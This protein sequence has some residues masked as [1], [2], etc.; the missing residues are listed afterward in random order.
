MF[1]LPIPDQLPVHQDSVLVE[2]PLPGG[3][4]ALVR[5]LFGIPQWLQIGGAVLGA[6]VAAAIAVLAWRR[7]QAMAGWLASRSREVRIGLAV[8]AVVLVLAAAGAGTVS[9]NYMQHDNGFC[10]GCHVMGEAYERFT[11]SEHDTLS[12]HDCHQQSIFAST[13]QLYLWVLERPQDIGEHAKVPNARCESCHVTDQPEVWQHIASTAGH[14]AHLESDSSALRDVQCVTC[15]GLEVHSFVPVDST[16]AQAGCHINTSIALGPMA[17]QTSLH[18]ATCHEFTT[19][20]PLLATRD[21]AA[22]T[23]RPNKDQCLSCH[24]MRAVLEEFDV[25]RDP[26]RGTCGMCHNPHEQESASDAAAT[27][28]SAGCH[29]DWRTEQFHLGSNHQRVGERCLLCHA[30]HRASVDPSDCAVCHQAVLDRSDVPRAI[31]DRLRRAMPFDTAAAA[32]RVGDRPGSA[33]VTGWS[34]VSIREPPDHAKGDGPLVGAV[35]AIVLPVVQPDTFPHDR[36]TDLNCITCHT[37]R[38]GRAGLVF[39]QPR[40]CLLCHHQD[41]VGADCAQCHA[42]GGPPQALPVRLT[43]TVTS[44]GAATH[45]AA[46]GHAPH[47]SVACGDCHRSGAALETSAAARECRDCHDD[48]HA[49][50]Q[51]CATCHVT[52]RAPD[53]HAPP[54]EAHMACAD[55]HAERTIRRLT[56]DREFCIACHEPQRAGHYANR[57]CTTCHM[58]STPE[59]WRRHLVRA[60]T[61]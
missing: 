14:R 12:C 49:P 9:W 19:D 29:G 4:A 42:D 54:V 8:G 27:C 11:A 44:R 31:R 20:V 24:E 52:V 18:C 57:Q 30:P 2:S 51:E 6:A 33:G 32:R 50:E 56:P 35:P 41:G 58:L 26:H 21:S 3:V 7:R 13:R 37:T 36:H 23:L 28:T 39:A 10:T 55:C 46:F 60:G 59:A 15:H 22:G 5:L 47:A 43:V 38:D 40:G 48:H 53:A 34:H 16:C 1:Q 61:P 17:N 25:V 45:D